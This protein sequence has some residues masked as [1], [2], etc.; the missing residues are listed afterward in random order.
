MPNE[1]YDVVVIGAGPG[2][3]AA[4]IRL[5]QLKKKVLVVEKAKVGGLCLNWGCIPTKAL[6]H[7]LEISARVKALKTAGLKSEKITIDLVQLRNWKNGVVAKLTKGIEYLFRSNKVNWLQAEAELIDPHQLLVKKSDGAAITVETDFIIVA[8]GTEA[9]GLPDLTPDKKF[10]ITTD[11][12]LELADIP[13]RLLVIGAGASGLE[14]GTI[15][16]RLG[17][18]VT[19]VEIMTQILPGM[20]EEMANG[21]HQI[22]SKQGLEII[23]N[24]TVAE[25]EMKETLKVKIV[26]K[27]DG[28]TVQRDFDKILLTVGRKPLTSALVKAGLKINER[29]YLP[30]DNKL[31]TNVDNVFAI[32]DITGPPLLAHKASKQGVVAAEIIAG[33]DLSLDIKAIPGCIFTDPPLASVGKSEEELKKEGTNIKVG[34]FPFAASGKAATM[35]ETA[36]FVK[37]IGDATSNKILGMHILGPEAP[38]LI[39]EGILGIEYGLKVDDIGNAV[40]P[41]PTLSEA[42]MEAAENFFGKAIHIV[43]KP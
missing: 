18:K 39:G 13:A 36:G 21:L 40:H 8:T 15:Y 23:L 24:S 41:H 25:V 29:G 35:L 22:L 34:R 5:G 1:K 20:D 37:I 26:N 42:I 31:R 14:M 4:A 19:V 27:K 10:I 17:S 28:T 2:G 12:A 43:N 16:S 32:G 30:V 7:V 3:Y 33:H 9:S 6:T 38:S 11:E